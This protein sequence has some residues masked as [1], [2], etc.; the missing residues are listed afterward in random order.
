MMS[1]AQVAGYRDVV[2]IKKNITL[3]LLTGP[4]RPGPPPQ[5]PHPQGPQQR[6][7]PGMVST[8]HVQLHVW[9]L[10]YRV[11]CIEQKPR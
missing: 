6:P 1:S 5:G 8:D 4:P 9:L 3:D 11:I 10:F 2:H 7:P